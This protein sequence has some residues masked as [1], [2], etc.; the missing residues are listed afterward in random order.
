MPVQRQ[1]RLVEGVP[2]RG[3]GLEAGVAGVQPGLVMV[4]TWFA[5]L[6]LRGPI[7]YREAW[8]AWW[9]G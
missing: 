6:G 5:S 1:F 9:P 4:S 7:R 8:R 3:G 2:V